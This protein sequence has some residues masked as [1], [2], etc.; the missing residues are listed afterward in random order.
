LYLDWVCENFARADD[1]SKIVNVGLLKFTLLGSEIK[2][3]F[4]ETAKN[5]VDDF[6]IFVES[7]ALNE[8]I[9]EIDCHFSF[10]NQIC[11]DSIHQCLECGGRVGEPEEH[12]TR[13]KK[14]LISDKGCL[15]FIAFFDLDIVIAPTNI[16]LGKD[17]CI[18]K[19]VDYIQ[20]KQ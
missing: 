19:L 18:P 6:P 4:F 13:F 5:F 20:G 14:T 17:L 16:K 15:P 1:Q 12:D 8:D 2:I 11:K 3:V 7:G 9:T 10:S